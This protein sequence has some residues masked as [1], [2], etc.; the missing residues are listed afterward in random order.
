MTTDRIKP[1]I[2]ITLS[3]V[4]LGSVVYSALH[5]GSSAETELKT[6]H[7]PNN[8]NPGSLEFYESA[9]KFKREAVDMK[10][11]EVIGGLIPHH[12]LAADLIAEFFDNLTD[13]KYDRVVL[14]GPNH[15]NRGAKNII[16]G[17]ADWQ[18]PYGTLKADKRLLD[19]LGTD[20]DLEI[21][22]AVLNQEHSINAE[23]AFIKKSWPQA[24]FLPLILNF[25]TKPET[26]E[27]LGR[28]ISELTRDKRTLVLA[29]IDFTHNADSQTAQNNDRRSINAI[30]NNRFDE[31]YSLALDSPASLYALSAY[32]RL[33]GAEFT[34]LNNQNSALLSG[35]AELKNVTSYITGYFTRKIFTGNLPDNSDNPPVRTLWFGDLMLDRYVGDQIDKNGL[36]G[37]FQDIDPAFWS[38]YDIVGANLEG[39]VTDNGAHYEPVKAYDFAFDP[40]QIAGLRKYNF[41]FFTLANNHSADQGLQGLEET[42]NN[43]DKLNFS[44]VGCGDGKLDDCS[45]KVINIKNERIGLLCLSNIWGR[46]DRDGLKN[47]IEDLKINSDM[48][49]A[50][51]HWG[52]EYATEPNA[53]QL[54]LAHYLIDSGIDA[55]IG[56]HPHVVQPVEIYKDKPIFYSLGNF[57]FDQYFSE[58]TQT[59][60]GV[61]LE[62]Q[63]RKINYTLHPFKSKL[64]RLRF[65]SGQEKNNLISGIKNINQDHI[66]EPK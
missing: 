56:H 58:E 41:N 66:S 38:G 26:A 3:L 52:E 27:D 39:A 1:I 10:N 13:K 42:R 2:I 8:S 14:I 37:F 15:F 51:V 45:A 30:Q 65:L 35:K 33:Q 11:R 53:R 64:S 24:E 22:N 16:S 7:A 50:N 59:G 57:I 32:T 44:Y 34:L 63:N 18:T 60:L 31:F 46:F 23:V 40:D 61:E 20:I 36:D 47:I 49:I 21:N 62:W 48:I 9:Y 28:K 43:L 12:L 55:I 54:E 17:H 5:D 19:K 6:G 25:A 4:L 29:S